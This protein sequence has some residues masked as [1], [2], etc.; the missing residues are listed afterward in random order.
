MMNC[1]VSTTPKVTSLLALALHHYF[2]YS[3][4]FLP[5]CHPVSSVFSVPLS[6]SLQHCAMSGWLCASGPVSVYP[7][8]AEKPNLGHMQ[9][10][11]CSPAHISTLC[12]FVSSSALTVSPLVWIFRHF[13]SCAPFQ[14]S[15]NPDVHFLSPLAHC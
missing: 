10:Q 11:Q 2:K 1:N 7:C 8:R 12:S 13:F 5:L 3:A 4:A 6:L 9:H 15:S 14:T